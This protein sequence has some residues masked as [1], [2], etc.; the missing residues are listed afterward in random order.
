MKFIDDLSNSELWELWY[1]INFN[2]IKTIQR[3]FDWQIVFY[4]TFWKYYIKIRN[5]INC[6]NCWL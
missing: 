5:L 1:A 2:Y 4:D 6:V 3:K